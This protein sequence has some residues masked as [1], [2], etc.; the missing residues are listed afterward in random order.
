MKK[1]STIVIDPPWPISLTG[2]VNRR[3][4]RAKTLPY[5]TM[6][7]EEIKQ[8]PISQIAE[9]GAHIYC[10]TTNKMLEKTFDVLKTWGVNFHLV[11]VLVK[12]SGIAPCMG[13]VFGTEFCLL[14]FFGKPMLKFK[15]IGKLNW[16]KAMNKSGNHSSKPDNFYK[17]VEEMSPA[18]RI[19][20]FAR[21]KREGWD[22]WGN[23]IESDIDLLNN[24]K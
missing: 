9:R 20:L 24:Y 14:G 13:Y 18:S 1:Y 7:V 17:L 11:M 23:E 16:F 5:K 21:K 3:L 10:W 6:T 19:D 4:N 15:K 22:V 12:P 2:D 8:F